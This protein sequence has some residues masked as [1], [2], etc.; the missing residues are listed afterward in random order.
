MVAKGLS[1]AV[2]P[3]P[4]FEN[5]QLKICCEKAVAPKMEDFIFIPIWLKDYGIGVL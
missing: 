5:E 1:Y 3:E 2:Y 4:A